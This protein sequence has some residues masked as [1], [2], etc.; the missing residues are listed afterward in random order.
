MAIFEV[1]KEESLGNI[2]ENLKWHEPS[3]LAKNG[4]AVRMDWKEKSPSTISIY[5]NCKTRLVDTFNEIYQDTF[6][7]VGNRE[8]VF[9]IEDELPMQE[10]KACISMALRYHKIKYLP[11]LG[12]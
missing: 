3:Y 5:F 8:I 1:A 7:Y 10:L 9:E 11:L 4:S 2:I 6:T 12:E